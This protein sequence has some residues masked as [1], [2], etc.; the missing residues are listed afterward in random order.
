MMVVMRTAYALIIWTAVSLALGWLYILAARKIKARK[1]FLAK[2][3]AEYE[4]VGDFTLRRE[5]DHG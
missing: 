4:I 5:K 3:W 2:H 1:R